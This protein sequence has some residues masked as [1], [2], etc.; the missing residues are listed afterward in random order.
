MF[1][2]CVDEP[3]PSTGWLLWQ[4][5]LRCRATLDR[6]L[7]P[8]GLTNAQYGVLAALQGLSGDGSEPSQ[9]RLADFAGLEP[10]Y[11]S[12]LVRELGRRGLL[13]RSDDPQDSRAVR[14]ALTAEGVRLVK[15]AREVVVEI[16]EWMLEPLGGRDATRAR[17]LHSDLTT[18]VRRLDERG[19]R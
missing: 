17:R 2:I 4:S 8:L 7:E 19:G 5:A 10:M 11:V 3:V 15:E 12:K 13:R 18:L 1:T 16:D 14:L 6:A 9:R